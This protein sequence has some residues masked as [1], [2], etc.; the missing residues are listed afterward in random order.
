MK[1]YVLTEQP[2]HDSSTI[3]GAFSSLTAAE[4]A[5]GRSNWLHEGFY[6]DNWSHCVAQSVRN[7]DDDLML[8]FEFEVA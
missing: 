4:I 7:D 8:I 5:S 1:V 3:V 2:Y 6:I